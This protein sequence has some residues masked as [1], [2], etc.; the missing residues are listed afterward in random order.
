MR[1]L[2]IFEPG[3]KIIANFSDGCTP[4]RRTVAS[5]DL[6]HIG[7]DGYKVHYTTG[8]FDLSNNM[9]LDDTPTLNDVRITLAQARG[10]TLSNDRESLD[11][12]I[13]KADGQILQIQ[14]SQ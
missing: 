7:K 4:Y 10:Y 2:E 8:G 12:L 1:T 9:R 13:T 3:D 6:S 14:E 11:Y 5:V